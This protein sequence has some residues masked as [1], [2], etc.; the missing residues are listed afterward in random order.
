ME[1]VEKEFGL[2]EKGQTIPQLQLQAITMGFLT[3]G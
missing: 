3:S 2:I 1:V